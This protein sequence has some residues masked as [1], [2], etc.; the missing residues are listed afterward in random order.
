MIVTVEHK[1]DESF[2]KLQ[3]ESWQNSENHGFHKAHYELCINHPEIAHVYIKLA[4]I[5]SEVSEAT[6]EVRNVTT[7]EDL[8]ARQTDESGKPIGF[9]SEL[10]DIVIRVMDLAG[11]LGIDLGAVIAD[12]QEYNRLREKMHGRHT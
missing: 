5:H 11:D 12:K 10:A 1:V 6:E 9:A 3:E 7:I 2:Q 4:L 8:S